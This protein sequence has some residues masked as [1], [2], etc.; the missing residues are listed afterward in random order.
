M[1]DW[2][3][4]LA[5]PMGVLVGAE[6]KRRK[7]LAAGERYSFVPIRTQRILTFVGL[8]GMVLFGESTRVA[9]ND[10]SQETVFSMVLAAVLAFTGMAV[11]GERELRGARRALRGDGDQDAQR[12]R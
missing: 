7:M 12:V 3:L 2:F 8:F 11:L 1:I 4:V 9:W 5:V 6:F 10:P